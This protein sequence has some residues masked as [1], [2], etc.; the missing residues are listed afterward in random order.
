[1]NLNASLEFVKQHVQVLKEGYGFYS[2]QLINFDR[3]TFQK[4]TFT[5]SQLYD[6][7]KFDDTEDNQKGVGGYTLKQ[8]YYY[9]LSPNQITYLN[10]LYRCEKLLKVRL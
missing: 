4:H 6:R 7:I 9:A 1:M 5:D 3:M 2:I 8:A 10:Y